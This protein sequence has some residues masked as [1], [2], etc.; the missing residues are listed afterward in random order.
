MVAAT[1]DNVFGALKGC[2]VPSTD[3]QGRQ[4]EFPLFGQSRLSA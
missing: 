3:S 1:G 4:S 2:F